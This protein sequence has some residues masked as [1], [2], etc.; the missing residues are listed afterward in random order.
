MGRLR[1]KIF[2]LLKIFKFVKIFVSKRTKEGKEMPKKFVNTLEAAETYTHTHTHTHTHTG[3]FLPSLKQIGTICFLS[4]IL[5][6][7]TFATTPTLI[8]ASDPGCNQAVLNTTSGSAALEAIYTPNTINTTWYTG[9]GENG[10]YSSPTTCDYGDT[11]NLPTINPSRPGYAFNG[12]RL[13]NPLKH[14]DSSIDG[15]T[16][17]YHFL[18]NNQ[19][20]CYLDGTYSIDSPVCSD[21]RFS[22]LAMNEWAVEF[23]YGTVYGQARCQAKDP[24]HAYIDENSDNALNGQIDVFLSEYATI[25]GP[26]KA[27]I[28]SQGITDYVAGNITLE[29]LATL[30]DM[31]LYTTSGNVI[32]TG[33]YCYCRIIG[34]KPDGATTIQNISSSQ[35]GYLRV[36]FED[37]CEDSCAGECGEYFLNNTFYFRQKLLDLTE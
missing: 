33:N 5:I 31:K 27:T 34:Y 35:W 36:N 23:S 1:N 16:K 21:S 4:I 10:V 28:L 20:A 6:S 13:S 22:N 15:I 24:G 14:I 2:H 29:E 12:W 8:P 7:P 26:E 32:N 25:A 18:Y 11:I 3:K 17:Y 37:H 19:E 30:V 9:Y